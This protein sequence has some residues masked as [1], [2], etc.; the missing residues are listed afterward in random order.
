MLAQ[1]QPYIQRVRNSSLVERSCAE[2][3]TGLK[4]DTEAEERFNVGRGAFLTAM[5]L[6]RKEQWSVK[7][8][9]CRNE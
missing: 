6:Y 7:K 2:N 5:K 1:K 3:V 9:E 4:H 8:R